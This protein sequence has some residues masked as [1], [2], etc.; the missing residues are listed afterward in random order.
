MV[1]WVS[2]PRSV[3]GDRIP[4]AG[5]NQTD[6]HLLKHDLWTTKR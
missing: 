6:V 2:S 5:C 4:Q 1:N 3:G